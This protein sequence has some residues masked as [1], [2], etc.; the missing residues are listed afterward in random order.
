MS[1]LLL[2]VPAVTG[3]HTPPAISP[4]RAGRVTE[5][6]SEAWGLKCNKNLNDQACD[7]KLTYEAFDKKMDLP[8]M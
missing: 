4:P 1:N 3:A 5:E 8:S 2:G 7:K 6:A